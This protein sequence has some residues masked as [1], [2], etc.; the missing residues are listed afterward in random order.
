VAALLPPSL[1][2]GVAVAAH[3]YP[4]YFLRILNSFDELYALLMLLV[5]RYFLRTFGGSFT[6]NFYGL[7]RERVLKIRGGLLPRA[8]MGAAGEAREVLK[9]RDS[10]MWKN[11]AVLVGLPYIKR[12]LDESY[13]IHVAHSGVLASGARRQQELPPNASLKAR[14]MHYYKWFLRR[15]YPSVN[16]AYY[17]SL[18]IFNLAYLCDASKYYSPFLWLISTRIRRLSEADYR[19]IEQAKQSPSSSSAAPTT[20]PTSTPAAVAAAATATAATHP[21]PRAP[22]T[23]WLPSCGAL[24][25]A[26]APHVATSAQLVLPACVLALKALEWWHASDFSSHMSRTSARDLDLPPPVVAAPPPPPPQPATP[27]N[28]PSPPRLQLEG[29]AAEKKP[30]AGAGGARLGTPPIS[31]LSLLPIYTVRPPADAATDLC[32]ICLRRMDNPTASPYGHVYC[33][34][35]IHKWV[36]GTHERQRAFMDGG[37][38]AAG[39]DGGWGDDGEAA[40]GGGEDAGGRSREGRWESGAG[41]DAVTGRRILGGSDVLRRLIT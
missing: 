9:L 31:S 36:D 30:A 3:R 35:C 7:K 6:E 24:A 19:A 41:R 20:T 15:M 14:F 33:Y 38:A 37:D 18:M 12:K 26:L 27:P 13:D 16:A 40:G 29:A 25:Q 11:L 2:Y 5:E 23:S 4:R 32:P 8:E 39:G 10:D 21:P 34:A 22:A 1:R 17:L 28:W